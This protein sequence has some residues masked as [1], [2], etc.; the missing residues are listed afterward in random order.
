[1]ISEVG[2]LPIG[3]MH[4]GERC[5]NFTL[6]PLQVKDSLAV[7]RSPDADKAA[8]DDE[9]MG[10]CLLGRRLT[11][12]GVPMEVQNLDFMLNLYDDDLAEIMAAEGRLSEELARFRGEV[13][14]A[15]D[16]GPVEPEDPMEDRTA[17]AGGGGPGMA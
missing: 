3:V 10:L 13:Q 14:K 16:P 2:T 9:Y 15:A 1:V 7:R 12:E 4:A 8:A 6:R 5:R 11:I 17:D